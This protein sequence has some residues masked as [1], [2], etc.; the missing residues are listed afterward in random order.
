MPQ[1]VERLAY[2]F[3]AETGFYCTR[4]RLS[5]Q[6]TVPD[7][8]SDAEQEALKRLRPYDTQGFPGNSR[9]PTSPSNATFAGSGRSSVQQARQLESNWRYASAGVEPEMRASWSRTGG[10]ASAGAEPEA[11]RQLEVNWRCASAGVGG[12]IQIRQPK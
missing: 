6:P 10:P 5:P 11:P 4:P 12:A 1:A 8:A 9:R 2:H 3:E 7:P